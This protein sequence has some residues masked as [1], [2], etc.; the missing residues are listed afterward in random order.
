MDRLR[1]TS[2]DP[3]V[4]KMNDRPASTRGEFVLYWSQMMRRSHDNAALSYA[5]AR[6]NDMG[7][8]C[9]VY[10]ALRPDY[11]HASDRLHTFVLEGARETAAQLEARGIAHVFFLPPTAAAAR[12]IVGKLAARAC[13][14]V[15]DDFPS[16]IVP[17]QNARAAAHAPCEFVVVDDC[18]VIPMALLAKPEVAARTIRPKV[19]RALDAWLRPIDEPVPRAKTPTRLDLPFSA[20][21]LARAH[22]PAL[23]AA[24]A[25]DHSVPAVAACRG[26]NGEAERHL[27][28]FVRGGLA[29]YDEDRNDPSRD[30]TSAL[31]PYLHFGMISARRIAIEARAHQRGPPLDAFLEQL[32]VRR[33]LSFNFARTHADHASYVAL[34]AWARATLE[35]HCTDARYADLNV[36]DLENARSPDAL[37]NAT[38]RELRARGTVQSYARMLWG[39]LPLLWM[40]DPRDAHAA[41]VYLNDKWAMDGRDPNGYAN[42]SWCFG[43]HDR[44]WPERAVFGNVRAMTSASA[45][46][47]LDFSAYLAKW[48]PGDSG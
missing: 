7:V 5:V 4:R 22:I 18:A 41:M 40:R 27:D 25:I 21:D 43:L 19:M 26:G 33:A 31:S 2:S 45:L 35:A 42:V 13:V 28:A 11:P 15:S 6:A 12:G 8:P 1:F 37:W 36:D 16:F 23:V 44:P 38:M 3:R 34:P 24:C 48:S 32:I 47:K 29:R 14:V 17:M 9:V 39:K 10:E 20:L 30:A 46:K